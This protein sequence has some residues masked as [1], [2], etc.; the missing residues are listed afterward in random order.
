MTYILP[1]QYKEAFDDFW[2]TLMHEEQLGQSTDITIRAYSKRIME[3]LDRVASSTTETIE[4][5]RDQVCIVREE[6]SC[7]V[8]N[9]AELKNREILCNLLDDMVSFLNTR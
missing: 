1:I 6:L 7:A 4:L 9:I 3:K 8:N 2:Q 5:S